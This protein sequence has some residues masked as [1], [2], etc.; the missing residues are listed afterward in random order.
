LFLG[1]CFGA[2]LSFFIRD[3][4]TVSAGFIPDLGPRKTFPGWSARASIAGRELWIVASVCLS[5]PETATFRDNPRLRNIRDTSVHPVDRLSR[6]ATLMPDGAGGGGDCFL[7]APIV[8]LDRHALL[9]MRSGVRVSRS[10]VARGIQATAQV[11]TR[12]RRGEVGDVTRSF[13][14]ISPLEPRLAIRP[15]RDG[16]SMTD[17]C[18]RNAVW[19]AV[20]A[21]LPFGGRK[22]L[23]AF[24]ALS[25]TQE[26][27]NGPASRRRTKARGSA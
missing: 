22:N 14:A 15:G 17:Q 27:P 20:G 23:P 5:V 3:N 10:G 1:F 6:S 19:F 18:H 21:A 16:W 8:S 24:R 13:A 2:P 26:G 7:R 4:S 9:R 12:R 25:R 11:R